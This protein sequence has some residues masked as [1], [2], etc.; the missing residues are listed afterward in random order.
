MID[1]VLIQRHRQKLPRR[2]A[3]RTAPG[4]IALQIDAVEVV[5]Q[6]HAEVDAGGDVGPAAS[7]GVRLAQA[8]EVGLDDS[9]PFA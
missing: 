5:E 7:G 1:A 8:V 2:E 4:S 6:S 9:L 3:V